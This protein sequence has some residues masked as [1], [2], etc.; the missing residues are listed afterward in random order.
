MMMR[1]ETG[2]GWKFPAGMLLDTDTVAKGAAE[3]LPCGLII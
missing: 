1:G 3:K 2:V